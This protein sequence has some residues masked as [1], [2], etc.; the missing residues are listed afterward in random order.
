MFG[1]KRIQPYIIITTSDNNNFKNG[2]TVFI[3]KILFK[4]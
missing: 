4:T 2:T 3:A 1:Q